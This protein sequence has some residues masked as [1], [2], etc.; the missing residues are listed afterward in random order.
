MFHIIV[1]AVVEAILQITVLA[2]EGSRYFLELLV[3]HLGVQSVDFHLQADETVLGIIGVTHG[4][5]DGLDAGTRRTEHNGV[6]FHSTFLIPHSTFFWTSEVGVDIVVA[7]GMQFQQVAVDVGIGILVDLLAAHHQLFVLHL[8]A[9]FFQR[10]LPKGVEVGRIL[11]VGLQLFRREAH[12]DVVLVGL[13]VDGG[14]ESQV[15]EARLLHGTHIDDGT[16]ILQQHLARRG[17]RQ[18]I[19]TD[20]VIHLDILPNAILAEGHL[21][22]G[23]LARLV[24]PVGMVGHRQPQ[25]VTTIGI[26]LGESSDK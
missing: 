12:L 16:A 13:S 26:V 17:G 7:V 19:L 1:V 25:I 22:L 8:L 20:F 4:F 14:L 6:L 21:H 2:R 10:L 15:A 3:G 18:H 24:E 11:R 5:L 9:G 23:P